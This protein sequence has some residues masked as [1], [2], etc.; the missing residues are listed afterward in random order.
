MSTSSRFKSG[1]SSTSLTSRQRLSAL[2]AELARV[3]MRLS[4]RRLLKPSVKKLQMK[5]KPRVVRLVIKIH[6]IISTKG[7]EK[8]KLQ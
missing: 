6:K 2:G 3:S 1:V 4:V 8:K 5:P 7:K